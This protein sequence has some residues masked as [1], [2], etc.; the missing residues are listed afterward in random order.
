MSEPRDEQVGLPDL[1]RLLAARDAAWAG[2]DSP[3]WLNRARGLARR[4]WRR[5]WRRLGRDHEAERALLGA[6]VVHQQDA[7]ARFRD[8]SRRLDENSLAAQAAMQRIDELVRRLDSLI[9]E[10]LPGQAEEVHLLD[11]EL[12][13]LVARL[14]TFERGIDI[15]GMERRPFD[16]ASVL[17]VLAALEAAWPQLATAQA[18][19]VSFQSARDEDLLQAA[20][21]HFGNRL[22]AVGSAYS[23]REPNDA[24]IH[25][26]ASPY[27][28]RAN[29]LENAAGRLSEGDLFALVTTAPAERPGAHPRLQLLAVRDVDSPGPLPLQAVVWRRV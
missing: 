19:E 5:V 8:I 22:S 16:G 10:A 20:S 9:G 13:E 7:T 12:R 2:P 23:Y 18:V 27:R 26:D 4:G 28:G 24:W 25:F 21:E 14:R 15:E 3:S 29:L 11:L 1:G 6:L 17:A